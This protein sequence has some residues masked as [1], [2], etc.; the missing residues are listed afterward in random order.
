MTMLRSSYACRV[1]LPN[2]SNPARAR[3][4]HLSSPARLAKHEFAQ[5]T[6]LLSKVD[7]KQGVSG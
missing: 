5:A 6:R 4:P 3:N 7:K 1:I 2:L